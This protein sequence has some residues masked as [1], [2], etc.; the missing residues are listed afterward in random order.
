MTG[1]QK[2]DSALNTIAENMDLLLEIYKS[3]KDNGTFIEHIDLLQDIFSDF[4]IASANDKPFYFILE[5]GNNAPPMKVSF[6][7]DDDKMGIRA[8][9]I[10]N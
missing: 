9:R 4:S 7:I 1:K 10:K 8:E 3:V 5:I 2:W 6:F